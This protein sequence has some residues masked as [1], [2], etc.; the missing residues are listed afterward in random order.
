MADDGPKKINESQVS[1]YTQNPRRKTFKPVQSVG[2]EIPS[3]I[4]DY[5]PTIPVDTTGG[6]SGNT[7]NDSG[8]SSSDSD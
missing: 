2:G 6:G 4:M 3:N 8:G 1:N 7:G 5:T